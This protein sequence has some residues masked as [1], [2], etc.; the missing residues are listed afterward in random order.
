MPPG[1]HCPDRAVYACNP[2]PVVPS[3]VDAGIQPRLTLNSTVVEKYATLYEEAEE[4]Q[5]TLPPLDVFQIDGRL[6]CCGWLS[7]AGGRPPGQPGNRALS[8]VY[9]HAP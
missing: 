8:C 2:W 4:G 1:N 5:T 9:R 3:Q 7:P 6:L